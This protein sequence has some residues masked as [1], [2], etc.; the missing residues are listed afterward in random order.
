MENDSNS[1][2]FIKY[3]DHSDTQLTDTPSQSCEPAVITGDLG[4]LEIPPG[5]PTVGKHNLLM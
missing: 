1:C 5:G 3:F 4:A 2:L